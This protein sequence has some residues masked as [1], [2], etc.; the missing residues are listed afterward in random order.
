MKSSQ[1]LKNLLLSIDHK[2]YPAYKSAQGSYRFQDYILSIDHVQG[3]P[4]AA[5]SRVS[6]RISGKNAGFSPKLYDTFPKRIALQDHLLRLFG[7]EIEQ[8]NFKARGSGKSGLMAVSRC[9]QEIL[10]RSACA[11]DPGTDP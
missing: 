6:L 8:Y 3:D 2:S 1:D 11:I 9:G 4:F 10:E 7:R 5:P